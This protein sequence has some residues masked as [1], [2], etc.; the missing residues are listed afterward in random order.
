MLSANLENLGLIEG[1][2]VL[3]ASLLSNIGHRVNAGLR[4][5]NGL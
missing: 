4:L 3:A 5:Y 1:N 2:I